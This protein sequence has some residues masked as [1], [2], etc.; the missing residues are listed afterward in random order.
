MSHIIFATSKYDPNSTVARRFRETYLARYKV[1]AL[2]YGAYTAEA[3]DSVVLLSEIIARCGDSVERVK[4]CLYQTKDYEGASGRFSI[5][6]NGD[7]VRDY[8]M[9]RV[10]DG[11][12]VSFKRRSSLMQ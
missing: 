7:A 4:E 1:S 11:T 9:H 2:P 5:D 12:V 3:Y 8:E 6:I 10:L